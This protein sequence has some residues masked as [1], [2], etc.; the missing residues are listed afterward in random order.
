MS[1]AVSGEVS[2][3]SCPDHGLWCW[4]G[5]I[6]GMVC[7]PCRPVRHWTGGHLRLAFCPGPVALVWRS[8][9]ACS[10]PGPPQGMED[11]L[12]WVY[13][14]QRPMVSGRFLVS[15]LHSILGTCLGLDDH[16]RFPVQA[17]RH[18]TEGHLRLSFFFFF[19]FQGILGY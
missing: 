1:A 4:A 12:S 14:H 10:L 11:C 5:I 19:F 16:L 17:P 13:S 3:E 7:L 2:E 6:L 18:Q 15:S 8:S 9:W